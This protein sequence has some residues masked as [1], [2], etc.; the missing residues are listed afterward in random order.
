M[1]FELGLWGEFA[2]LLFLKGRRLKGEA[3]KFVAPIGNQ[4]QIWVS[5]VRR[6]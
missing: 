6:T 2:F 3:V 1:P 4:A 5:V